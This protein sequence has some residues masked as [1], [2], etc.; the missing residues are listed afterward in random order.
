VLITGAG[1]AGTLGRELMKAFNLAS[2]KY[3]IVVT[4]S[5]PVSVGLFETKSGYVIP[6]S[7]SRNYIQVILDICK[8]EK[9]DVLVGG[10]EP[11]IE[12]IAKNEKIFLESNVVVLSNPLK[13]IKLC[14]DKL[15]LANFLKSKKILSPKTFS[16]NDHEDIKKIDSYP[17]IIKPR[18]GSGS[19]NV[20]LAYDRN[21]AEFFSNYLKKH[22]SLPLIQEY[23]NGQPEEFTIGVLYADNGKLISSI[24]MKRILEGSF[25]TRQII[26]SPITKKKNIISSGLSQGFFDEFNEITRI[27]EKI[28]QILQANGP[29]NIQCRKT[30]KGLSVF[31]IN[32]RF[33]GTTASRSLVGHNEPD[34]LCRYRLF[35]ETT[36]KKHKV[37][38]VMRDLTEK[39]I[40]LDKINNLIRL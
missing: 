31:E 40:S 29:I 22:G 37:G 10:S 5:S 18:K 3:R 17:V 14:S 16:F 38:Y 24:A 28:A 30:E 27:G 7:N 15:R 33:S 25:S 4:N 9:I 35:G 11:E 21:E 1:G 20:F 19:K 23:I 13:V 12:K 39:Y 36:T 6:P 34:I 2:H 32:P 26:Q 8:K